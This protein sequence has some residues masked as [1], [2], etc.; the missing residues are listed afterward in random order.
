[1]KQVIDLN[2]DTIEVEDNTTVVTVD[3]IHYLP[4]DKDIESKEALELSWENERRN[5][6]YK[7]RRQFAY[8]SIGDQ[9]DALWKE[10]HGRR[11]KGEIPVKEASDM[12]DQII[13]VK[14]K[15]PKPE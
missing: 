3:G 2:G 15:Y 1:M 5:T 7:E 12:L 4:T 14:Q 13:A 9:L 11:V 10:V 8:P 6:R